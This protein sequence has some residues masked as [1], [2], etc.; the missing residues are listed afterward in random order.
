MYLLLSKL[1]YVW[2]FKAPYFWKTDHI[3]MFF[4]KC[5]LLKKK[6][7]KNPHYEKILWGTLQIIGK[8]HHLLAY[9]QY[10][11]LCG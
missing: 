3:L 5:N 1:F 9:I 6:E 10:I 11:T 7:K 8:L 2:S 4:N